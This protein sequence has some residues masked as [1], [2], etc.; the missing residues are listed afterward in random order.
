MFNAI[1]AFFEQVN[2]PH[3]LRFDSNRHESHGIRG[4]STHV[5]MRKIIFVPI[6][7]VCSMCVELTQ[8]KR[9]EKTHFD[10]ENCEN[11]K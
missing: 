8:K 6:E 5:E 1:N 7:F 2:P 10:M 3:I 4:L 9:E 11:R